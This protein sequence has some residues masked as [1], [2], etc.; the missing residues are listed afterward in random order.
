MGM[1]SWVGR[2]ATFPAKGETGGA[3]GIQ[4]WWVELDTTEENFLKSQLEVFS[5][6]VVGLVSH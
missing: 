5:F 3:V 4:S 2:E 1:A 6:D